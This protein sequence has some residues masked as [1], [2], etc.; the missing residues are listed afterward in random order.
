MD[1]KYAKRNR[2][3]DYWIVISLSIFFFL[4]LNFLVSKIDTQIDLSTDSRYSLSSET[5]LHLEKIDQP[6]DII[7]TISNNNSLPRVVQRLLHDLDLLLASFERA[8]SS[9]PIRVHRIDVD[10]PSSSSSILDQYKIYEPNLIIIATPQ[11]GK[12]I[13][14]RYKHA[15]ETNP[16]DAN[17]VFRSTE[18]IARQTIWEAG[19]YSDW[20]ELGNGRLEPGSFRGEETLISTILQLVNSQKLKKVA[21]FT[22][23]HGELS[24][25]DSSRR[26]GLSDFKKLLQDRNLQVRTIDLSTVN[27]IPDDA[28]MLVVVGPKGIFQDEEVSL[29]RDFLNQSGGSV[30]FALDPIEEITLT[31]R[32]ALGLRPLL[33]EWGIRCHDMLIHDPKKENFDLFSG[34]YFLRTYPKGKNHQ[35]IA[36]LAQEGY[37]ISAGRCRPVETINDA[38]S[39]FSTQELIFSSRDSWAL[40][41]W[42]ER[43][44][45]P[46]KNPLLDI[47]GPVPILAISIPDVSKISESNI[48][49][50]GKLAVLGCSHVL[51]NK[52]MQSAAGNQTLAR[53]LAYWLQDQIKMLSIPPRKIDS[54]FVSM[55][56]EEFKH[57]TYYFSIVP[58]FIMVVGLF[59]GWLR[60]EL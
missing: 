1:F 40:S 58:I 51:T 25:T 57:S 15:N 31:D 23:G 37:S 20:R 32:P 19:F 59:I 49:Q 11:G 39:I 17:N 52:N 42:T 24:P 9:H 8:K 27:R 60:K 34:S 43:S 3:F 6:I 16:Y 30:L 29:I 13:L 21:Y 50:K 53:N 56:N 10:S 18:S 7:I 48:H 46:D 54:Y 5:L 38:E 33:K 12:R 4:G 26:F 41:S 22:K 44:F 55:N 2:K 45:P 35:L 14:Y 36:N 28:K 47:P